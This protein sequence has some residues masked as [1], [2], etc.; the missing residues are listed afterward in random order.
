M[1][2]VLAPQ[3]SDR[4]ASLSSIFFRSSTHDEA[5]SRL[6]YLV[7]QRLQLGLLLGASGSGMT[8]TL[9]TLCRELRGAQVTLLRPLGWGPYELLWNLADHLGLKPETNETEY[10]IWRRIVERFAENQY[11][12]LATVILCDNATSLDYSASELWPKLLKA[13]AIA[14]QPPVIVLALV[15][16][17]LEWLGH[18]LLEACDL[19]IEL[20]PW[21]EWDIG[22]C[23]AECRLQLGKFIP[24]FDSAA[25]SRVCERSGGVPRRIMNWIES[26]CAH[27]AS[28]N[29]AR[30]DSRHIDEIREKRD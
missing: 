28:H 29:Q 4:T 13:G 6:H 19:R 17:Q 10:L 1:N 12:N 30:I 7:E 2:D 27:A 14:N 22:S 25:I 24:E 20:L 11:Q 9:E 21:D 26:A 5:L 18:D 15:Q 23:L 3:Q 8:T 16:D